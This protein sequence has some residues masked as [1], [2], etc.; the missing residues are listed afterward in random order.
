MLHLNCENIIFL[1][2]MSR[3]P[4]QLFVDHLLSPLRNLDKFE[5]VQSG[6]YPRVEL[7]IIVTVALNLLHSAS[8]VFVA[9]IIDISLVKGL[10]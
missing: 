10:T 8:E 4:L 6:L 9:C 3:S 2:I 7:D 5:D 1:V